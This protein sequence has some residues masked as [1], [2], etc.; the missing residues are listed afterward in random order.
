MTTLSNDPKKDLAFVGL[1]L[2]KGVRQ[3]ELQLAAK[4]FK[5]ELEKQL[6]QQIPNSY[7]SSG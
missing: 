1:P 4:T 6:Q 2:T 7:L 3:K 5:K